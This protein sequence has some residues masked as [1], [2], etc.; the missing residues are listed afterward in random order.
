MG[1]GHE[2]KVF[3]ITL[4]LMLHSKLRFNAEDAG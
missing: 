2:N 1:L 3:V 4:N